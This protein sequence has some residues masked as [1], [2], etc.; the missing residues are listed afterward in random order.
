MAGKVK[1][2]KRQKRLSQDN[3]CNKTILKKK[4]ISAVVE[5]KLLPLTQFSLSKSAGSYSHNEAR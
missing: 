1:A 2:V 3:I 5:S 4:G